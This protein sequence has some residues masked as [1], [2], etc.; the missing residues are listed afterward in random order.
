MQCRAWNSGPQTNCSLP[1]SAPHLPAA[2]YSW[3]CAALLPCCCW[4]A[5]CF[6]QTF[7]K[8]IWTPKLTPEVLL[9]LSALLSS[10]SIPL[11]NC[12]P[13]VMKTIK[14]NETHLKSQLCFTYFSIWQGSDHHSPRMLLPYSFTMSSWGNEIYAPENV[15]HLAKVNLKSSCCSSYKAVLKGNQIDLTWFWVWGPENG[16]TASIK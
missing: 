10:C 1:S 13:L 11:P 14:Q 2:D 8:I 4:R 15:E 6:L 5:S 3:C 16:N 7:V 9:S 12:L